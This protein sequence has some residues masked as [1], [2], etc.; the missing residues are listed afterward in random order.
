MK[1][2]LF[3]FLLISSVAHSTVMKSPPFLRTNQIAFCEVVNT[4][5]QPLTVYID[6]VITNYPTPESKTVYLFPHKAYQFKVEKGLA[7]SYCQFTFDAKR[8]AVRAE[9]GLIDKTTGNLIDSV[10]AY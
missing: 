5:D 2:L 7:Y 6:Y 1:V 3:S 4:T 9:A 8:S 10:K